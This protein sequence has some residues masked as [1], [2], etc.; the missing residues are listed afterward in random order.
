[1]KL[2]T[3]FFGEILIDKEKIIMFEDGIPGFENL[4]KFLFMTDSKENSPICWLQSID[5][6]D[7]VF[8]M[9]DFLSIVPEYKPIVEINQVESLGEF[10][11]DDLLIYNIMVIPEDIKKATVNLKA[12]I[13]IN[14]KNKKGKQLI[15]NNDEYEIKHFIYDKI[16]R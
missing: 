1:M 16:K 14:Y 9:V 3:K 12:P 2:K 4:K 13:V 5:E 7:I 11:L 10:E 15:L 6:I 8:T